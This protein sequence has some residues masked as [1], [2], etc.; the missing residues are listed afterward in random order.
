MYSPKQDHFVL[1][2]IRGSTQGKFL[3]CYRLRE[4][5]IYSQS[6]IHLAVCYKRNAL[7]EIEFTPRLEHKTLALFTWIDQW[8]KFTAEK[9]TATGLLKHTS[10]G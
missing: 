6:T 10:R 1:E 2:L 7:T 5:H 8:T 9:E 4:I 3:C